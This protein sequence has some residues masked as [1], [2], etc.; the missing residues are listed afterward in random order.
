V[1]PSMVRKEAEKFRDFW[2]GKPG[3][4]GT[5]ADWFATWRNW[6]RRAFAGKERNGFADTALLTADVEQESEHDRQLAILRQARLQDGL[7]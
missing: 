4:D 5:K 2:L 1:P 3:K 7:N 6:A